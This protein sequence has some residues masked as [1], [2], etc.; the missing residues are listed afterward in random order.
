MAGFTGSQ[1]PGVPVS[2]PSRPN[3]R[4]SSAPHFVSSGVGE[5]GGTFEH[6]QQLV[7]P[8]DRPAVEAAIRT[9]L[10]ERGAFYT[11]FR[12]VWP[13]GSLHWIAGTG[14][15][16]ADAN[17]DAL[18]MIGIGLDVTE[19]RRTEQTAQFLAAASAA[20]A[21]IV[22]FDSTLQKVASLAVPAFADWA[23]VDLLEPGGTLRRVAVS[24]HDPAQ[25]ARVQSLHDP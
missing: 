21:E 23:A 8:D 25:V 9:A 5:F 3:R 12:N 20:L 7:H 10:E 16:F 2:V 13:D 17:G 19:R 18:R 4:D 11:E 15:V 14:K 1:A 24:H 6:F 22:D